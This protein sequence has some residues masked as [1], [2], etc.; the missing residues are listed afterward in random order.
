MGVRAVVEFKEKAAGQTALDA[1]NGKAVTMDGAE[2]TLRAKWDGALLF[3]SPVAYM[4]AT[5]ALRPSLWLR[6]SAK[7]PL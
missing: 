3:H 4:R 7:D 5:S 1:V 6:F 2:V